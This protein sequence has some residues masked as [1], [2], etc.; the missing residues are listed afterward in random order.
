MLGNEYHLDIY[1][2]EKNEND[3]YETS[4]SICL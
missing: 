3:D 1:Y 4:F 2:L